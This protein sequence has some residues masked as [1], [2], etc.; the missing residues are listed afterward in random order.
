MKLCIDI[1]KS[2]NVF[3]SEA[4]DRNINQVLSV[5]WY[6]WEGV[7]KERI[8]EGEYGG[9]LMYSCMKIEQ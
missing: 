8:Y 9:N 3:F 2:K 5:V 4:E 1:L 6:Q 7:C